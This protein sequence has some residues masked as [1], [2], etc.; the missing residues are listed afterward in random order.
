VNEG[1]NPRESV[2]VAGGGA[3]GFNIMPIARERTLPASR[4]IPTYDSPSY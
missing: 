4:E 2:V 1:V 3:A